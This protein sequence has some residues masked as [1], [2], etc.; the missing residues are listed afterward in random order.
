MI[1]KVLLRV[2]DPPLTVARLCCVLVTTGS[3]Y[4]GD[5]DPLEDLN[6]DGNDTDNDVF[7]SII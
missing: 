7:R 3:V 1:N 5:S 6:D 2:G 4:C